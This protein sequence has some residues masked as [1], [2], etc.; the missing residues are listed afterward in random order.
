MNDPGERYVVTGKIYEYIYLNK[1][2]IIIDS[3]QS[4]AS[5]LIEEYSLGYVCKSIAQFEALMIK[6]SKVSKLD[7]AESL[8]KNAR[9]K[10][11]V[12]NAMKTFMIHLNDH[13]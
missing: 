9:E 1:P 5:K 8:S 13:A 11:N 2:I 12:I 10:F 4:E 7:Q 3:Y 6:L